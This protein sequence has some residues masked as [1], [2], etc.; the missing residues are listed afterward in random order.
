V[1]EKC[2]P[3]GSA[4]E[5]FVCALKQA[6][7][8]Q[9][10]A[11]IMNDSHKRTILFG[12]LDI[13]RRLAEMEAMLAGSLVSSPFSQYVNDLSPT[14]RRVIEDYFNRVRSV[15]LALLQEADIAL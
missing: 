3:V 7:G 4:A 1:T 13:H 9:S 2:Q 15:M 8:L 5:V 6:V 11:T 10:E 12:F 14:E